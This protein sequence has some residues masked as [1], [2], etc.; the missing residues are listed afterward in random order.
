MTGP[1]CLHLMIVGAYIR[2]RT[3]LQAFLN[4][5]VSFDARQILF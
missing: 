2:N 4:T 1:L 5:S 3:P